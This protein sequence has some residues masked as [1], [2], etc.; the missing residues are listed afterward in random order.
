MKKVTILLFLVSL[1]FTSK[2]L[3]QNEA[4]S[5]KW[6]SIT[7]AEKLSK[8]N[9]KKI[10]ID[11]YTDWCRWCKQL[12]NT[13]YKNAAIVKYVNDNFYAVKLNAE[14]KD[15]ISYQGQEHEYDPAKRINNV[16]V[17]FLGSQAGYPTTTFLDEKL[18]VL[19]VVPGYQNAD[20]MINILHY[21][22]DNLYLTTDWNTYIAS[23]NNTPKQ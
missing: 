23:L 12:D 4:S 10:I 20:M 22:G 5:I 16:A 21:F 3:A 13:T 17:N 14:S 9:P 15:K 19:S 6:M 8:E 18:A 2:L 1:A 11:V 7:E